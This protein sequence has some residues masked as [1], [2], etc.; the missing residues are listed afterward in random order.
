MLRAST[1]DRLGLLSVASDVQCSPSSHLHFNSTLSRLFFAHQNIQ[2]CCFSSSVVS[3]ETEDFILVQVERQVFDCC[4]RS[5]LFGY[6]NELDCCRPQ[7]SL[8]L[9]PIVLPSLCDS[10][11]ALFYFISITSLLTTLFHLPIHRHILVLLYILVVGAK[12][13]SQHT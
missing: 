5:K 12:A 1:H 8:L 4:E 9:D 11:L 13:V 10:C 3:K 7:T 6:V 2:C